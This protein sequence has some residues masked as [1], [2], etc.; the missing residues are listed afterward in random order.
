MEVFEDD[1]WFVI[2]LDKIYGVVFN[3]YMCGGGD[4][5][6]VFVDNGMNVYDYGFGLEVVVVDY[7]VECNGYMLFIDGWI[8]EK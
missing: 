1:V 4:G 2:D 5:Y 7:I 8:E 6:F 3:N